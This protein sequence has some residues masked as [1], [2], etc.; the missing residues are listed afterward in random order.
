MGKAHKLSAVKVEREK[1]P[2][3]YS[4]GNG[5]YLQITSTGGKS[6][7]FRYRINARSREMGLGAYRDVSLLKARALAAEAHRLI[8][9]GI[10]PIEARKVTRLALRVEQSK[11]V[12][13]GE[14]CAQYIAVKRHEWENPKHAQQW[15]NTLST[16]CPPIN[17]FPVADVTTDE[18]VACL[19]PIWLAKNETAT[20]LRGRIE[21]VLDWATVRKYRTGQNPAA[22]KNHLDTLFPA[23]S[24][25]T[26]TVHHAALPYA[27]IGD[28][29]HKLRQHSGTGAKALEFGILTAARSG[30][31][32]GA[33]WQ[34]IDLDAGTWVI[35]AERMKMRREHKVPL[36]GAAAALLKALPRFVDNDLVFPA[37]R[38]GELSDM[39]LGAVIK[40]MGLAVTQHGF[41]STFR[42]W[43]AECTNYSRDVAEMALAHAI[44]DKVEAAYRRGDLIEKRTQLMIEWATYCATV[45]ASNVVPLRAA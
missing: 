6:W 17:G 40:R 32:R 2:G 42:D 21:K 29:M 12:T 37:P 36:S 10:D 20:R 16:Y 4:D 19:M 27:E 5:L 8:Q 41:R 44:G 13:F 45:P 39:T 22:W 7:I 43:A 23:I 31:I 14:C 11:G 35:P 1:V 9:Q 25:T 15:E 18:V 30:E 3:M 34:E 28:F 33:T 26:R 38:G 24:K